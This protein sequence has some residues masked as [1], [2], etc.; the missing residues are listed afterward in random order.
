MQ[1]ETPS[2]DE[3]E[4]RMRPGVFSRA[5]FLGPNERLDDVIK[6]DA[7]VL[8]EL[9]LDYEQLAEPVGRAHRPGGELAAPPSGG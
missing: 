7:R 6:A 3:L 8:E 9:R 4:A 5:G 2:T 1:S